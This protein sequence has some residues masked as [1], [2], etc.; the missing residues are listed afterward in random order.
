MES[1]TFVREKSP[2]PTERIANP[3]N[4]LSTPIKTHNIQSKIKLKILFTKLNVLLPYN[5]TIV[6]LENLTFI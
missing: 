6:L 2:A 1:Y 5:P 3:Q 4:N